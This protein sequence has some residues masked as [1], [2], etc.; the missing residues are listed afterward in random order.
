MNL[1]KSEFGFIRLNLLNSLLLILL[2]SDTVMGCGPG[3]GGGKQR[4]HKRFKPL[5]FKQHV[6][7]VAEKTLSASGPLEGRITKS[8]PRFKQLSPNYN[9]D[10]IFKDEEGTGEDRLMTQVGF[11][12]FF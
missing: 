2:A 11:L 3:T 6:P 7:N 8:D 10:I 5:V 9:S 1:K 12:L 4:F